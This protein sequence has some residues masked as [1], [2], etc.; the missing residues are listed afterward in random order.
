MG[1]FLPKVI[2]QQKFR[3]KKNITFALYTLTMKKL[4]YF[5]TFA[6]S[7]LI[8]FSCEPNRAENGDLLFGVGG[9]GS[10]GGSGGGGT[11][12]AGR[13]LTKTESHTLNEETG[14]WEDQTTTY[15]YE[16]N[17]FISYT[18][19]GDVWLMTYNSNNKISKITNPAQTVT[20]EYS[21]AN[22]S[23]MVSEIPGFL[24]TTATYTYNGTQLIKIV[25][26]LDTSFPI[27]SKAYL[28]ANY[29][30]T[31]ANITKTVAKSGVY[32]L[33]GEL[34]MNPEI[35]TYEMTYDNKQSPMRLLPTE[36]LVYLAGMAPHGGSVLS[37]N[38]VTQQKHSV[39]GAPTETFD[40]THIYDSQGYPTKST[41]SADEYVNYTYK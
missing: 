38:N 25:A 41:S 28:E 5:F 39:T 24:K 4:L 11:P 20:L 35:N 7:L 40:Y 22:V 31:G 14:E 2:F 6:F 23:K 12:P 13:L 18:G 26:I 8:V 29:T 15:Q 17:K 30:Y 32:D 10:D 37:A 27:P 34:Q 3:S 1:A 33:L 9:T 16:G 21:G 36:F 19:D